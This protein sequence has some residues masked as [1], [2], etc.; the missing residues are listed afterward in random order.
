MIRYLDH[1]DAFGGAEWGHPSDNI[2]A[3]LSVADWLA[4][5]SA[6]DKQ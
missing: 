6:A 1:N 2:G 3:L 4:R 5:S